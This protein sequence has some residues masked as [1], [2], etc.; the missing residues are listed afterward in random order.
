MPKTTSRARLSRLMLS[1]I[2]AATSAACGSDATGPERPT[3]PIRIQLTSDVGDPVGNGKS[4]EY[5]KANSAIFVRSEGN[6]LLVSIVGDRS[7]GGIFKT[8]GQSSRLEPGTYVAL[9]PYSPSDAESVGLDWNARGCSELHGWFTI[10]SVKY[11][12]GTLKAIDLRFEQHC[13]SDVPALHGSIHWTANDTTRPPGPVNPP[14]EDLWQPPSGATPP[15]GNY[16]YLELGSELY[17]YTPPNST[18]SVLPGGPYLKFEAGGWTGE[19]RVM[20]SLDRLE[21]GYYGDL[22]PYGTHNPAKGGFKLSYSS[23]SGM[24]AWFVVD[25]VVYVANHLKGFDLRFFQPPHTYG[26]VRWDA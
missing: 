1:S 16:L 5:S 9:E 2:L 19:L 17:L 8:R 23:F 25:R 14:P 3:S 10:D 12:G 18:I 24:R 20:S 6:R 15:S 26:A 7:W 11:A 22:L 13:T 4:Y 21:P